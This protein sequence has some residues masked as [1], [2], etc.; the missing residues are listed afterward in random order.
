VFAAVFGLVSRPGFAAAGNRAEITAG[1]A[2]AREHGLAI[3]APSPRDHGT[4]HVAF[5][6]SHYHRGRAGAWRHIPT[7]ASGRA[8]A[9][10][11]GLGLRRSC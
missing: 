6:A 9:P 10:R 11:S 5:R 2:A 1:S 7:G 8:L 3:A 4:S